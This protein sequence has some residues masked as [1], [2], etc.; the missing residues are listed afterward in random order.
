[1]KRVNWLGIGLIALGAWMGSPAWGADSPDPLEK[2]AATVN[3]AATT[4]AGGQQMAGQIAKELNTSCHCSSFST[5]SVTAQRAQTGWGWGEILIADRLAQAVSKQSNVSFAT[6]LAEVTASRQQGRGWGE[7]AHSRG[8]NLGDLVSSVEKSANAVAA[9]GKNADK[10]ARGAPS[11]SGGPDSGPGSSG[12]GHGG[13][14]GGGGG[15]GGNG[16]TG[17]DGGGGGNG[18]GGGGGGKGH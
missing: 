17:G 2:S 16:G 14:K 15:G 18:G 7:I 1:M 12:E 4:S 9:A 11:A 10:S 6:A 13:G 5:A 3:G 8:V